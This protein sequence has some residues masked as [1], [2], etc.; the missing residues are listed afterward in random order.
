LDPY[1]GYIAPDELAAFERRSRGEFSGVGI[2]IGMQGGLLTVIAPVEGSSAAQ[3]GVLAGDTLLSIDGQKLEGRSVFDVE[4]MLVG[5][6]GTRVHIEV[7]HHGERETSKL[8][9]VRGPV[10]LTTVRG[11]RRDPSGAWDYMIDRDAR[12]GYVR[13]S[14]FRDNTMRDFDAALTEL[15]DDG[16]AALILDM[17]FNPGG[18][19]QQAVAMVDRFVDGG[20]IL[21]TVT[22]RRA[23]DEYVAKREGTIDNLKL[24]VLINGNSASAAEI[25]AGSLQARGRAEVVG[26]RSF[27]KGSVQHLIHLVGHK[28]AVKLT[29][30]YYRLPDGRII[31][32]TDKNAHTELWGVTPDVGIAL[33]EREVAA[34]QESRRRVDGSLWCEIPISHQSIPIS[35]HVGSTPSPELVRDRQLEEALVLARHSD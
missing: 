10:H 25:V 6:P 2:E 21:S 32:R 34:I 22:R 19:M 18:L 23:V 17:R 24:V 4:E 29:V 33:D 1:S 8:N 14:N 13:V 35:H 15:L 27:G 31:H 30:A 28:A 9:L 16:A 7:R 26:E 12:V 5:S 20:V 3:A 11:F